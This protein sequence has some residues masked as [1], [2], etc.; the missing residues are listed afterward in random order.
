MRH[1]ICGIAASVLIAAAV[2]ADPA[3]DFASLVADYEAW[4]EEQN[5]QARIRAGDLDAMRE[6]RDISR[7]TVEARDTQMADFYGRLRAIDPAALE[8]SDTASYAVLD[9]MLR[10]AVT[11]PQAQ[12]M[13]FPFTNDSGF[14]TSAD[15]AA[16][17]ARL[18][19]ADEAEAWI[20]RL[21]AYPAHMDAW[22]GWLDE[23]RSSPA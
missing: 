12:G 14:H 8:G 11:L 21:A 7:E 13:Y 9:H 10:H 20:D 6:W 23:A 18:R 3:E 2:H 17:S 4:S 15:F 1:L 22:T 19:N 16:M 5:V